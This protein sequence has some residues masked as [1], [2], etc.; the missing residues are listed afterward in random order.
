MGASV[1]NVAETR[2]SD[3]LAETA[4]HLRAAAD[5]R[6]CWACG[7]LRHAL[8][9]IDRAVPEPSRPSVLADAM[10]SAKAHLVAQRY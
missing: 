5:A 8:D 7:C 1:E 3:G 4:T 10:A 9:A 6:K 2:V